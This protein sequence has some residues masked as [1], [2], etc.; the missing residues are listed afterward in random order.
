MMPLN[1]HEILILGYDFAD[2]PIHAISVNPIE[3]TREILNLELDLV[4]D[5]GF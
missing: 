3:G 2:Y 5:F 4:Y 1:S